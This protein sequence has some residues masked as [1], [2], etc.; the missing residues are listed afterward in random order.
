[1]AT[2]AS[3]SA[4]PAA[5][6][7]ANLYV[8]EDTGDAYRW[9]GTTYSRISQRVLSTGIQ[10]STVVGR[11]VLTAVDQK[12]AKKAIYADFQVDPRDF[13]GIGDGVADDTAALKAALA[14][15]PGSGGVVQIPQGI[16]TYN[17]DLVLKRGT[18]LRGV[19]RVSPQG[20]FSASARMRPTHAD[21][22]IFVD[23]QCH[24]ENMLVDGK[25]VGR[26]AFQTGN[27]TGTGSAWVA[28]KVSFTNVQV[29]NFTEAAF[30]CEAVQN[31][32]FTNVSCTENPIGWWFN[33]GSANNELYGCN[34]RVGTGGTNT[35]PD[36]RAILVKKDLTDLRF[37]EA[38]RYAADPDNWV[39]SMGTGLGARAIR[40]FG[41]IFESGPADYLFEFVDGVEA[42]FPVLFFG[43]EITFGSSLAHFHLGPDF[44]GQLTISD[45]YIQQGGGYTGALVLAESGQV[46]YRNV[47]TG[48]FPENLPAATQLSGT[49]SAIYDANSAMLIDSDFETSLSRGYLIGD[50][51]IAVGTAGTV[52]WNPITRRMIMGCST[53]SSGVA[54]GFRLS[55]TYAKQY[56][57]VTVRFRIVGADGPLLLKTTGV[58]GRTI[59]TVG[60]GE[61]ELVV[62]LVPGDTGFSITGGAGGTTGEL[63]YFYAAHGGHSGAYPPALMGWHGV[64]KDAGGAP[65]L[66][67]SR[68]ANAVNYLQIGNRA[69]GGLPRIAAAGLDPNISFDLIP[70]GTGTVRTNNVQVEV[71][72]HTHTVAQVTGALSWATVPASAAAPGTA[73]QLAYDGTHLYVCVAANTWK[74]IAY[75]ATWKA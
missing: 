7:T 41:G 11:S 34:W 42:P 53:S 65:W 17:Q 56:G 29:V 37:M 18:V 8:A 55:T 35:N 63:D 39:Q 13:G 20:G 46:V 52:S 25:N 12:A 74:T 71:K 24:V 21:A 1:M 50:D 36:A 66:E 59:A 70:K 15:V 5:G 68:H 19:G 40:V 44:Q 14:A 75:D 62:E 3:L 16:W 48:G 67:V 30:V 23:D 27:P 58:G 26:W 51:W 6:D 49:A 54:A 33:H 38:Q 47:V 73:G 2:F 45:T 61:H 10:D 31:S 72:G 22:R 57:T 64:L 60:N 9:T 69:T 43:S 28:N 32:V 4:F